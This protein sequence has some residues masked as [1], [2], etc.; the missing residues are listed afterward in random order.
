MDGGPNILDLSLMALLAFFL[1]RALLR[2]FVREVMGL[3]GVVAAVA[4]SALAYVPLGRF[5]GEITGSPSHWWYV[6]AFVAILALIFMFFAYLGLALSRLINSG[7][8]SGLD[9]MAGGA[10]GLLKG[11]LICYL[12]LHLVVLAIPF[13][14]PQL[15]SESFLTPYVLRAG[16]AVV[17]MIPDRLTS[18]LR[19]RIQRLKSDRRS[20]PPP[21]QP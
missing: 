14:L 21:Q 17:E 8:F 9:R 1:I 18:D 7:P 20:T 11:V 2:G 15:L 4:I 5:L 13:K 12:L 19:E 3:A 10:V 16:D 6:V